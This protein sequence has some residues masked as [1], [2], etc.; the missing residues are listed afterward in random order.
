MKSTVHFFSLLLLFASCIS[1]TEQEYA[2]YGEAQGTTYTIKYW[3]D[4]LDNYQF[5][6]D[7]LLKELDS[8]L[9]T[10]LPSSIISQV[11]EQDST[12]VDVYFTDV[13]TSSVEINEITKGAFDPSVMPLVQAWGFGP[14]KAPEI[15][16]SK[17]DSLREL[18]G[19][20]RFGLSFSMRLDK[21]N[22]KQSLNYLQ[23]TNKAVK[24]DFNGIAQ[25]YSVDVLA[26]FLDQKQVPGYL[27][28]L[29]GEIKAKG[30]NINGA[31]W[32]IGIDQPDGHVK[33]RPLQATLALQNTAVA[34]SGNYRKF[35]ILN[36]KKYAHTID[37]ATGYPVTHSLL[38]VTVRAQ[39]CMRA[40]A[41]ATAF[42]VMGFEK[43]QQFLAKH[44]DLDLE[45]YFI[46]SNDDGQR[47]SYATDGLSMVLDEDL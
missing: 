38:S 6:I 8:S 17:I 43:S 23:K 5:E 7:S 15:D 20:S 46:Y 26:A 36:G 12:T 29:G 10:Y 45:A 47:I 9:S 42:M 22:K 2:L 44:Q 30:K 14:N 16:T 18:V 1:P 25:G 11:N 35:Y 41:F 13:F 31:W 27:I 4:S 19:L 24:L 39:E 21:Q 37:P 3:G 34:T 33:S 28:E 32:L 40:D